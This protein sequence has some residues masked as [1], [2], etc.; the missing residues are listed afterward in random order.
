MVQRALG[1]TIKTETVL[2]AN[3]WSINADA[4]ELENALLNLS[5]NARDAMPEGGNLTIETSNCQ[6][7]DTYAHQYEMA[8]GDYV[9]IA[10]TDTGTGMRAPQQ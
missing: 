5:V 9:L 3:V 1:E 4:G 2:N 7:D 8:A 6:I 10:V